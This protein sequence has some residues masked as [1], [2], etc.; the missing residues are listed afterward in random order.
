MSGPYVVYYD[1]RARKDLTR[2]ERQVA[3]RVA[4][5]ITALGQDPRPPGCRRL[6]GYEGLWRLRV[7]DYRVV[8][9]IKD[10][11]LMVLA[12]RIAHRSEVYRRL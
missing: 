11:E 5:A 8:Y 2:F 1:P 10:E 9:T 6:V 4:A 12:V 7:G 3:R